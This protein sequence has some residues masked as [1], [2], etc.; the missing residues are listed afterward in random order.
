MGYC[1]YK[2]TSPSGKAYIGITGQEPSVRFQGGNGYAGNE[3]FSRAIKKYG[4]DNFSHHILAD[5]LS[6]DEAEKIE[7]N[8]I[9][10]YDSTN[11]KKGYNISLGGSSAGKHSAETRDKIS[12][13][14]ADLSG[15]NNPRY[16]TKNSSETR[17]KI[18]VA[19]KAR[20]PWK[21]K[22][23]T[24]E[25]KNKISAANKGKKR[26]TDFGK[27]VS[28]RMQGNKFWLGKLHTEESKKK[29]VASGSVSRAQT[30][31]NQKK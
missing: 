21:G 20:H 30:T 10:R 2:H 16:G 5:N 11:R 23:Q 3:Y 9:A 15:E 19:L 18:R 28:Q 25:S 6:K 13:N 22:N 26:S 27:E 1:V 8:L 29:I 7:R 14:H 31:E 17:E 12:K 4:W 24:E